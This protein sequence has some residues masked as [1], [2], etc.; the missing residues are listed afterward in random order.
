MLPAPEPGRAGYF[1]GVTLLADDG[2]TFEVAR[3]G[4]NFARTR[5][6]VGEMKLERVVPLKDE[7][8]TEWL[9]HELG[10]LSRTPTYEAALAQLVDAAMTEAANAA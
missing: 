3:T 1:A 8:L 2:A 9:G 10:R 5:L 4:A 6:N 7:T